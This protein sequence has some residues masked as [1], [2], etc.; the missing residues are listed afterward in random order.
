M[1]YQAPW[2]PLSK[3]EFKFKELQRENELKKIKN[4]INFLIHKYNLIEINLIH[5]YKYSVG[6]KYYYNKNNFYSINE[7]N[8]EMNMVNESDITRAKQMNN[9]YKYNLIN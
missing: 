2:L 1:K 6:V 9:L 4:K 7:N 5:Y 3:E 8:G